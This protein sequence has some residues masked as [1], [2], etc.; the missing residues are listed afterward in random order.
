MGFGQIIIGAPGAG[1]TVFCFGMSQFLSQLGRLNLSSANLNRKVCI[2]NLDP[3]NENLPYTPDISIFDLCSLED[4]MQKTELGPNGGFVY[5]MEVLEKNLDW[6][7][8][9]IKEYAGKLCYCYQQKF[10]SLLTD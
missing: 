6:L 9:E 3:A 5:A 2:I 7:K 4:I 8:E 10:R 1:K